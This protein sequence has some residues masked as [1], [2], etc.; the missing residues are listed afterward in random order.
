MAV[1]NNLLCWVGFSWWVEMYKDVFLLSR[2]FGHVVWVK[3]GD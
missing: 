1:S 2:M 3:E